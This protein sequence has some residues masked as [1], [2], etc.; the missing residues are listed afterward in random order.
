MKTKKDEFKD[1]KKDDDD[2]YDE[3]KDEFKDEKK[4]DDDNID[5]FNKVEIEDN[6]KGND[7]QIYKLRALKNDVLNYNRNELNYI[8]SLQPLYF[9]KTVKNKDLIKYQQNVQKTI[10]VIINEMKNINENEKEEELPTNIIREKE[11]VS[12]D[13]KTVIDDLYVNRPLK[14]DKLINLFGIVQEIK[15]GADL[16]YIVEKLPNA[17]ENINFVNDFTKNKKLI[18]DRINELLRSPAPRDVEKELT[19]PEKYY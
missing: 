3:Y 7:L 16:T 12:D 5:P 18:L 2:K 13:I 9:K 19:V 6:I 15:K 8:T 1:E 14:N 17:F 4:D 11:T 10:D